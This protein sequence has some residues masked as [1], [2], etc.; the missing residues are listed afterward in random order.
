MVHGMFMS[1][2][3]AYGSKRCEL[4]NSLI[5][6]EQMREQLKAQQEELGKANRALALEYAV[7]RALGDS[8]TLAE[9]ASLILHTICVSTGWDMGTIWDVDTKTRK[10]CKVG[11]W[12]AVRDQSASGQADD[13]DLKLSHDDGLLGRILD[14]R[15]PDW[16]TQSDYLRGT[17]G[18]N[19]DAAEGTRCGF[20]LPIIV[21]R[22]MIGALE[23]YSYEVRP[24]DSDPIDILSTISGHIGHLIQRNR[25][26][27]ALRESESRFR[28]LTE[29]ASDAI[30]TID[31]SSKIVLVNPAAEQIFGYTMAE[32]IG[33]D[34]TM[35]M[36]ECFRQLHR[37]G[38]DRHLKTGRRHT[39]WHAIELPGLHKSGCEIP[40]EISF[41]E[42]NR[43]DQRFF[44][45]IA[46][47]I[48]ERKRT[49]EALRKSEE[50]RMLEME[51]IRQRIA[52]DLHDDIGSSLTKIALLS[53]AARQRT[54]GENGAHESL[55]I[56]NS[57]SNEL[58]ESMSDIVWAI[59][60]HKDHLSDLAQRMRRFASDIFTARQI[61]F[62][63]DGPGIERD[64]RLGA[65]VRRESFLI[66][67]ESINNIVKHADCKEVILDLS[68]ED[69]W[70]TLTI[71]DDG[72]GFDPSLVKAS[73]GY[74]TSQRRG[75]NGL[76]S[77]RRRTKELAGHLD[78]T[79]RSGLGT[80][81]SLRVPIGFGLDG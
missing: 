7:T 6:R 50:E 53:E 14:S 16:L 25:I 62:R 79:T 26:E 45:G 68:I 42:F 4:Q 41:G 80:T 51:R 13:N 66:F 64:R 56:I 40:L 75:G 19:K 21:G 43:G 39:D 47:D 31:T 5:D 76:A 22:K 9:A 32:M 15:K 17:F 73:T 60:P 20:T 24:S 52:A 44:T 46:R 37:A 28:T 61:S 72:T 1:A 2:F 67:K 29:A 63:F 36:P 30:I 38:L 35:L 81:V 34:L 33:Q 12:P 54:D 27:L 11:A 57:L 78:I 77:I 23:L 55:A 69:G 3:E 10:V 8:V 71:T 48:S 74:L 18:M 59:N 49:E 58:V 65:N 70:L